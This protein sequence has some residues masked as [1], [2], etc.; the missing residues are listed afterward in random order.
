[1]TMCVSLSEFCLVICATS[2]TAQTKSEDKKPGDL[3]YSMGRT[4]LPD[5]RASC[6]PKDGPGRSRP[7]QKARQRR[8]HREALRR[9]CSL[10]PAARPSPLS[11]PRLPGVKG[12][13]SARAASAFSAPGSSATA[14]AGPT[15]QVRERDLSVIGRRR[16]LIIVTL[17]NQASMDFSGSSACPSIKPEP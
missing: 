10:R 1:L 12:Q 16:L 15:K 7:A 3:T 4:V 6:S 14:P 5:T 13:P 17:L 11:I 9:P 8:V 2:V